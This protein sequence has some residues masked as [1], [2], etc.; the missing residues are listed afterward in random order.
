[1][2]GKNLDLI[3]DKYLEETNN[4]FKKNYLAHIIMKDTKS[5]L[6]SLDSIFP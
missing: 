4:D 5:D 3:M 6:H 2:L 1:M